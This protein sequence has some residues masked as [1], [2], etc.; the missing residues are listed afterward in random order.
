MSLKISVTEWKKQ[1]QG[2]DKEI[3]DLS[4]LLKS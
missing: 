4:T 1:A 3:K 2:L